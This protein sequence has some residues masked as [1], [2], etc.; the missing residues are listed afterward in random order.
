MHGVGPSLHSGFFVKIQSSRSKGSGKHSGTRDTPSPTC[1]L[2]GCSFCCQDNP[3]ANG[4][5]Y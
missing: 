2:C 4:A 5:H 3:S 1:K